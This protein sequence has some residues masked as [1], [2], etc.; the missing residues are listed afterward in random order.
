M[1]ESEGRRRRQVQILGLIYS[2]VPVLWC[3]LA[4]FVSWPLGP[5][6][7]NEGGITDLRVAVAFL[8]IALCAIASAVGFA[9]ASLQVRLKELS[10]QSPPK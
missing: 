5:N 10:D 9:L 7:V 3:I 4:A 1:T 2:I 8:A 6:Y